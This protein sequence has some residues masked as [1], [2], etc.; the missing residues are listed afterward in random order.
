MPSHLEHQLG[1]PGTC[2]TPTEFFAE[3]YSARL[4][5]ITGFAEAPF[6]TGARVIQRATA[7]T[8]SFVPIASRGP[9]RRDPMPARHDGRR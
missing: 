1:E 4:A 8:A 7:A 6:R 2:A 9:R 3:P 5:N